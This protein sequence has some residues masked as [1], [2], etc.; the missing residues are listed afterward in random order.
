MDRFDSSRGGTLLVHAPTPL[1]GINAPLSPSSH[2]AEMLL[3]F[4]DQSLFESAPQRIEPGAPPP[5]ELAQ[6]LYFAPK[7]SSEEGK[8]TRRTK[9]DISQLENIPPS[10]TAGSTRPHPIREEPTN[11]SEYLVSIYFGKM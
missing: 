11:D 7:H 3:L 5:L 9:G 1:L 4:Y 2:S 8:V 10:H 6:K